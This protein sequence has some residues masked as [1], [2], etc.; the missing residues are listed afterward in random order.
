M[1]K[2]YEVCHVW[3]LPGDRQYYAS[4]ANLVLVPRA[5]AQLTDHNDAVKNLLRRRAYEYFDHFIPEGEAL[6]DDKYYKVSKNL[7]REIK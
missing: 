6:P 5:L 3:D 2:D 7:W 4:I 1:F